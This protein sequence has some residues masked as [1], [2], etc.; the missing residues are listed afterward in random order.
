MTAYPY[1]SNHNLKSDPLLFSAMWFGL[2]TADVRILTDRDFVIGNFVRYNETVSSSA[3]MKLDP[4][5]Y[6]LK[7]TGRTILV[8]VTHIEIGYG[9]ELKYG[10]L[11]FHVIECRSGTH[12]IDTKQDSL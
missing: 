10:V 4:D 1:K 11:S 8:E 7:Y 12:Q 2:K 5:K 9:I 3:D 6:P